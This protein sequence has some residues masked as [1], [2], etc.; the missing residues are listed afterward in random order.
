MYQSSAG[1]I[2]VHFPASGLPAL[3]YGVKNHHVNTEY[4]GPVGNSGGT[5]QVQNN[6]P[7]PAILGHPWK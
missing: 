6:F 7:L 4:G 5:R 3:S 2:F 1:P